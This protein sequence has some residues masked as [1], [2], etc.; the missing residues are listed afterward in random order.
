MKNMSLK[1]N[2]GLAAAGALAMALSISSAQAVTIG[3]SEDMDNSLLHITDE[4][5]STDLGIVPGELFDVT[6]N[7]HNISDYVWTDFHIGILTCNDGSHMVENCIPSDHSDGV[8][9]GEIVDEATWAST[10]TVSLNGVAQAGWMIDRENVPDDHLFLDMWNGGLGFVV[11][12]GD[13]LNLAFQMSDN[14]PVNNVW[15]LQQNATTAVPEPSVVLLLG[16]G[17]LGMAYSRRN[18]RRNPKND[19]IVA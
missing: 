5:H 19:V 1:K 18:R 12:P 9:F 13:T 11:N 17:L 4:L 14:S 2:I 10:V 16:G 7:I 3:F 8:S 15:R 6:K